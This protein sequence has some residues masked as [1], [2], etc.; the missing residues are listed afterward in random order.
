[1]SQTLQI[2]ID[3]CLQETA[4]NVLNKNGLSIEEFVKLILNR[5]SEDNSFIF[6]IDIPNELTQKTLDKS[7]QGQDIYKAQNADDLFEQLGI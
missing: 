5:V 1:M 7:N 6:D 4:I 2:E 3:D